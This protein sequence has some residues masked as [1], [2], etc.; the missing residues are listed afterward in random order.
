MFISMNG[1]KNNLY[2]E[3]ELIKKEIDEIYYKTN[4]NY[5]YIFSS[6]FLNDLFKNE[7]YLVKDTYVYIKIIN[8]KNIELNN[9]IFKLDVKKNYFDLEHITLYTLDYT[10]FNHFNFYSILSDDLEIEII[11]KDK[12]KILNSLLIA[13]EGGINV[14]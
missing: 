13:K 2:S 4:S 11:E 1:I 8:C 12:M 3:K 10:K 14:T 9:K 5:F 6:Y 7:K